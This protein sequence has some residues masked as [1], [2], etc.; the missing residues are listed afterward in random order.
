MKTG[1]K[2]AAQAVVQASLALSLT[3]ALHA[4]AKAPA[5]SA[6]P[7]PASA[8]AFDKSAFAALEWRSIGPYRGGRAVAVACMPSQPFT[9]YFGATGGGIWIC[10]TD[11]RRRRCRS[12]QQ[13]LARLGSTE[14]LTITT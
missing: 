7:K 1:W 6:Q 2:R 13:N 11:F 14:R 4:Q 10:V 8:E 3:V 9:F 12:T 5:A